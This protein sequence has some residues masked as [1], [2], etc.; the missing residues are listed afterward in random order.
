MNKDFAII[1]ANINRAREGLRVVEEIARFVFRDSVLFENIKRLRHQLTQIEAAFG[2]ATT[3]G[4]RQGK[5]IGKKEVVASEYSRVSALDIIRANCSRVSES[6]RVIEELSKVYNEEEVQHIENIRYKVYGLEIKL[7]KKTPQFWLRNYFEQGIVY[8][9]SH[10][11]NELVWLIEHGAKVIQLRDKDSERSQVFRKARE[12]CNYLHKKGSEFGPVLLIINDY[13]DIASRLPVAGVH[14][15]QKDDT[16]VKARQMLGINKIIGSSNTSA[17]EIKRSIQKGVDY[18]SIGAVYSTPT[19]PERQA[20][21]LN[22]VRQAVEAATVPLV[23]IGGINKS[24]VEDVYK[25]G[26]K[27]VAVV[28]AAK[29]FFEE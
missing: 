13:I 8:T 16:I 22:M 5:D 29:S 3:V 24:N 12:L 2:P 28:R 19:K 25:T 4:T 20:V 14:L 6:M 9:I 23:A 7:L 1:D 27:N 17:E 10:D 18:V 26:V 11:V 21:G 15:G